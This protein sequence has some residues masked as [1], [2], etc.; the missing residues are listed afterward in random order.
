MS[1]RFFVYSIFVPKNIIINYIGSNASIPNFSDDSNAT[2]EI[3]LI[4]DIKNKVS[5]SYAFTDNTLALERCN[6]ENKS[7]GADNFEYGISVK[8]ENTINIDD[9]DYIF[10][11]N[12][13]HV[14]IIKDALTKSSTS[15]RN[16]VNGIKK[17]A[18]ELTPSPPSSSSTYKV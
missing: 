16:I 15:E 17:I 10:I 14:K 9:N 2:T 5:L 7:F 11:C 18:F 13:E 8:P 3:F 1:N 4:F 6:S 12:T